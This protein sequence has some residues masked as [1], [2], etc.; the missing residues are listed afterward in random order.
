MY[1]HSFIH[2]PCNLPLW[3]MVWP[4]WIHRRY[5]PP[6]DILQQRTAP[7]TGLQEGSLLGDT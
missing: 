7:S 4:V 5:A 3:L 1:S 2:A 6:L